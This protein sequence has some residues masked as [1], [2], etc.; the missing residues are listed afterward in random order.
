MLIFGATVTALP[1][2]FTLWRQP[3][4]NTFISQ[5]AIAF[6]RPAESDRR[7]GV[8]CREPNIMTQEIFKSGFSAN[9]F[10]AITVQYF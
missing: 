4:F 2:I 8:I 9:T 6:D 1:E 5:Y 3:Q 10:Q 7:G